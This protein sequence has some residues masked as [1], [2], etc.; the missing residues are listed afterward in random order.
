MILVGVLATY[1]LANASLDRMI[2]YS[3]PAR[4]LSI[5][6]PELSKVVGKELR[7]SHELEREI[8]VIQAGHVS[9]SELL[10]RIGEA[11][12]GTWSKAA[13]GLKLERTG[14]QIRQL[15]AESIKAKHLMLITM[16]DREA[17]ANSS[18]PS[19]DSSLSQ[20]LA[21]SA[22]TLMADQN[23]R[24]DNPREYQSRALA[25]RRQTPA[26]RAILKLLTLI[27]PSNL[28]KM[29]EGTRVVFGLHPTKMQL[30]LPSGSQEVVQNFASDQA[31]YAEAMK[32]AQPGPQVQ[33]DR[34]LGSYPTIQPGNITSGI[35]Q[36]ILVLNGNSI[37][38]VRD[39][40][41]FSA[42]LAIADAKGASLA[43]G[44]ASFTATTTVFRDPRISLVKEDPLLLSPEDDQA[45]H[46]FGQ[47]GTLPSIEE[48]PSMFFQVAGIK[49]PVALLNRIQVPVQRQQL[50]DSVWRTLINPDLRDP[51]DLYVGPTL[52]LASKSLK[53]NLVADIP[54]TAFF[55]MAQSLDRN[56]KSLSTTFV[57]TEVDR[58]GINI[59]ANGGFLV[60]SPKNPLKA[61]ELRVDRPAL[62]KLIKVSLTDHVPQL[63]AIGAYA[64]TRTGNVGP[65][66]IDGL[67]V[68]LTLGT[69]GQKVMTTLQNTLPVKIY[70]SL[71]PLQRKSIEDEGSV[72]IANLNE[73]QRSWLADDIYNSTDGPRT[74][75]EL[76]GNE[77][78]ARPMRQR[79]A[80]MPSQEVL[81]E[82]TQLLANGLSID[83]RLQLISQSTNGLWG[84]ETTDGYEAF[85][86]PTDLAARL[87][88]KE[89]PAF[90]QPAQFD[91]FIPARRIDLR[92]HCQ[93]SKVVFLERQLQGYELPQGSKP[94]AFSGL[95]N[96]LQKQVNDDLSKIR[97]SNISSMSIRGPRTQRRT[98]PPP[99]FERLK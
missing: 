17:K 92:L 26:Y 6:L 72:S 15:E 61:S 36:A 13:N 82:R 55:S 56:L 22:A 37:R 28:A 27:G 79:F 96:D 23:L 85:V 63:D 51:L 49:E 95:D 20:K 8:V 89:K 30:Q 9:T 16:L 69:V 11:T 47:A 14:V 64:L 53:K 71:T 91:T 32:E 73:Q 24:M 74:P 48:F 77:F 90:G 59:S 88:Q 38:L 10:S 2:S 52:T 87:Y 5:I 29:Q 81:T 42:T 80:G 75:V 43:I 21:K 83:G 58:A 31:Q 98:T 18:L 86:T 35:S 33:F 99:I 54:D 46:A 19:W 25:I 34:Q 97:S 1:G 39:G 84:H 40:I 44:E 66:D 65:F 94:V 67:Y 4:P 3:S 7:V 41:T 45:V 76:N 12:L 50:S 68:R 62:A 70:A 78:S 60:G 93:L 57:L